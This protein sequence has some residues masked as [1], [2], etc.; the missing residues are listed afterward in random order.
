MIREAASL[1]H[2]LGG[3][4]PKH[5]VVVGG[6]VPPLLVP[7]AASSHLGSADLDLSLSV[8]IVKGETDGYYRSLEK[9]IEPYFEPFESGFRWRKRERV[10]GV[11]LLVDF[12]GPEVESSRLEDGKSVV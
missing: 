3:I 6:L 10:G 7:G 5:L 1:F 11:R 9:A 8:A 12:L 4:A 2:L